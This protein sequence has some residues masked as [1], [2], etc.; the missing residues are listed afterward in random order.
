MILNGDELEGLCNTVNEVR[1]GLPK[2]GIVA[3]FLATKRLNDDLKSRLRL[4]LDEDLESFD[5]PLTRADLLTLQEAID[6]VLREIEEPEFQTRLGIGR[7]EMTSLR[8]RL[9]NDER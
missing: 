3:E 8:T 9:V 5:V 7:R 2:T 6:I 4:A 1:H